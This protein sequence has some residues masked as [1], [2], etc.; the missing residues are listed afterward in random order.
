MTSQR[1]RFALEPRDFFILRTPLLPVDELL[2]WSADL[3]SSTA[4]DDV[5]EEALARDHTRLTERLRAAV[6]RPEVREALYLASPDLYERL[7]AWEGR[8]TSDGDGLRIVRALVRYFTRMASRPTPFGLFAGVSVGSI[9]NETRLALTERAAC[10]HVHLDMGYLE[11]LMIRL[12]LDPAVRAKLRYQANT[13]ISQSAGH[14]HYIETHH[15]GAGRVYTLASVDSSPEVGAVLRACEHPAT[16]AELAAVLVAEDIDVEE[17]TSFVTEM[18]D[19]QLLVSDLEPAL[20]G[21]RSLDELCSRV[22][23]VDLPAAGVLTRVAAALHDIEAAPL[24]VAPDA[25]ARVRALLAELPVPVEDTKEVFQVDLRLD[26]DAALGAPVVEEFGRAMECLFRIG[27]AEARPLDGFVKA[28]VDR[29]E[30]QEVPLLEALD[31][32]VGIGLPGAPDPTQE[33]AHVAQQ[34]AVTRLLAAAL[35]EQRTEIVLT[36]ADIDAIAYRGPMM[37]LPPGCAIMG[38]VSAVDDDALRDG[39]FRVILEGVA[40][41]SGVTIFGRFCLTDPVLAAAVGRQLAEEEAMEPDAMHAE[42]VHLSKGR[43]G[44]V[45][46]RPVLRRYEI[47]FLGRSG[48]PAERQLRLDDLLVSVRQGRIILRSRRHGREVIPQLTTAHN[49]DLPDS[50]RVYRFLGNFQKQRTRYAFGFPWNSL[51]ELPFL[52]RVTYGRTV[53]FRAQWKVSSSDL[54][55]LLRAQ[56]AER[57][58]AIRT[59]R[60]QTRM[61]RFAQLRDGDLGLYVDFENPLCVDVLLSL[62]KRRASIVLAELLPTPEEAAVTSAGGRLMH[63]IVI[64]FVRRQPE[65]SRDH[66]PGHAR[67]N[68]VPHTGIR[69]LPPGSECLYAKLYCGSGVADRVLRD[70]VAPLVDQVIGNGAAERW[71]F[72]RYADPHP[73]IRLRFFGHPQRLA[74]DV[75]PA[76]TAATAPFISDGRIWR[77]QVDTYE[78]EVE[79]YGGPVGI[80]LAERLFAADSA[81]ALAVVSAYGGTAGA[82]QRALLTMVGI[83][84]LLADFGIDPRERIEWLVRWT[85]DQADFHRRQGEAYRRLRGSLESVLAGTAHS[86]LAPG[87]AALE[88]RSIEVAP[89]AAAL[90]AGLVSG[91]VQ[92]PAEQ[93]LLSYTH[94]FVNRVEAAEPTRVEPQYYDFLR[95]IHVAGMARASERTSGRRRH[96]EAVIALR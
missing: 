45:L 61:P 95:R 7:H 16:I 76:L 57:L 25:Y 93:L 40:G 82:D 35:A 75:L 42:L 19:A 94:M 51:S 53:L 46:S 36:D 55:P 69:R 26:S 83:D 67:P 74:A 72:L 79:R 39:K 78:R 96:E 10:R 9:G 65:T 21:S 52:P 20:T 68:A 11:A 32:E 12:Q 63:E 49:V 77:V 6:A 54:A 88:R 1:G 37:E 34:M 15:Q 89:I 91:A 71:F 60:A 14:L 62:V 70:A 18:I 27:V 56:G 73:H 90:R 59:W 80:G 86:E 92:G 58:R 33:R 22:A 87:I 41:P 30:M 44:N 84:R 13:S 31:E 17:A 8:T 28:F 81:A 47:P 85:P 2:A 29:Y 3:E 64:P 5:L 66:L 48:A 4:A 43:M 50:P 24:G 38:A 23:T